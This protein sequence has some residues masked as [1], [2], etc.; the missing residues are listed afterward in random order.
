MQ[1][2]LHHLALV[3]IPFSMHGFRCTSSLLGPIPHTVTRHGTLPSL[4]CTSVSLLGCVG[5]LGEQEP[6]TP[7]VWHSPGTEP[8]ADLTRQLKGNSFLQRS[9]LCRK[10][11]AYFLPEREKH[12]GTE[13]VLL[14]PLCW[15]KEWEITYPAPPT[16]PDW[17]GCSAKTGAAYWKRA[18][19][20]G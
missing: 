11:F 12:P 13:T 4:V 10:S 20:V 15:L 3:N 17:A 2:V 9:S 14:R 7:S 19:F 18:P 1:L 8:F 5:A 16:L 6:A